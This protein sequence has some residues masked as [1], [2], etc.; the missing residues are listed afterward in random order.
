MKPAILQPHVYNTICT[1]YALI[2]KYNYYNMYTYYVFLYFRK[3]KRASH[4][5][6]EI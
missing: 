2:L 6:S 3:N 1:R 4:Y 5:E